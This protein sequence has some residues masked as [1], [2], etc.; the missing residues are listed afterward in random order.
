VFQRP[1]MRT[2]RILYRKAPVQ[3]LIGLLVAA[4]Q[5]VM[6]IVFLRKEMP[7]AKHDAVKPTFQMMEAA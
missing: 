7:G 6:G 3:E 2:G 4:G 1:D 5:C